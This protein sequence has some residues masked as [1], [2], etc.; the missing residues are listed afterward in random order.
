MARV[1]RPIEKE[2]RTKIGL[3]VDGETNEILNALVE[4]TG[5]TKSKIFEEAIRVIQKR[6][7]AIYARMLDYQKNGE[8]SLLDFE[9]LI[10]NREALKKEQGVKNVG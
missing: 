7:E 8:D 9:E 2:N 4:K 1:G 3:S 10:K 6:E 5:K